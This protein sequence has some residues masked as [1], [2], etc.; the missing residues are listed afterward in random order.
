M[1]EVRPDDAVNEDPY[2]FTW[3]YPLLGLT[4]FTA[5]WFNELAVMALCVMA[6]GLIA[7]G[8]GL[9]LGRHLLPLDLATVH[10][11]QHPRLFWVYTV[12]Q[13]TVAAVAAG[14]AVA[15]WAGAID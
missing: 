12:M 15:L 8:M 13:A 4:A 6:A 10:R 1:K 5:L 14:M 3:A 9:H 2:A 7:F 11:D